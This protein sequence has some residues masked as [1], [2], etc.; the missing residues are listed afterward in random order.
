MVE[1][2]LQTIGCES[3]VS[4]CESNASHPGA[5]SLPRPQAAANTRKVVVR[6]SLSCLPF[7]HLNP[8]LSSPIPSQGFLFS[9][10]SLFSR[11]AGLRH[12]PTPQTSA[13]APDEIHP[14]QFH[15]YGPASGAV[16]AV[17][18]VDWAHSRCW[19]GFG[20]AANHRPSGDSSVSPAIAGTS[21]QW[22]GIQWVLVAH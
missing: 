22:S 17:S 1:E 19:P 7:R 12:R 14:G 20:L 11:T 21:S 8:A 10:S 2:P 3:N 16:C 6:S 4:L 5:P 18:Y 13:P 15:L 9:P